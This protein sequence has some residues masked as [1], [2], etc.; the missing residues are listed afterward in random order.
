[1]HAREWFET[2]RDV[3]ASVPGSEVVTI[4][5]PVNV[6]LSV[7]VAVALVVAA[8]WRSTWLRPVAVAALVFQAGSMVALIVSHE[9]SLLGWRE[10]IY[11]AGAQQTL[12]VEA[13]AI[14]CL[15]AALGLQALRHRSG[16]RTEPV[17]AM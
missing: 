11:T 16:G 14:L 10:P 5:F 15:A 17:P 6:A 8:L 12:A 13:G 3:P 9:A 4:G 1:M 2:Y 7:V